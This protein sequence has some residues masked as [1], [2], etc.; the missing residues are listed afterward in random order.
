MRKRPKYLYLA[1]LQPL[2][3]GVFCKG[4]EVGGGSSEVEE[5]WEVSGHSNGITK[6]GHFKEIVDSEWLSFDR[7]TPRASTTHVIQVYQ[8][9]P[10]KL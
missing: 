7:A 6:Y 2:R 5:D 4:R 1:E 8:Q 3:D 9:L 10:D